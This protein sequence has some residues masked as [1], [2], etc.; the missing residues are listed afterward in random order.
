MQKIEVEIELLNKIL[1][2]LQVKPFQEV[3]GLIQ[4]IS[5]LE[6]KNENKDG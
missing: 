1:A 3:A 6:A 4:E 2:Y 5:K